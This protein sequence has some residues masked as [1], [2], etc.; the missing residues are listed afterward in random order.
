[1]TLKR[2]YK[3][4]GLLLSPML[5]QAQRATFDSNTP[6]HKTT[7]RRNVGLQA[8]NENPDQWKLIGYMLNTVKQCVIAYFEDRET[9]EPLHIDCPYGASGDL[10][11]FK[12]RHYVYGLWQQA[13]E[14]TK[15]GRV[16]LEFLRLVGEGDQYDVR[17][18]HNLP[19]AYYQRGKHDLNIAHWY[20]RPS[21]Y[22]PKAYAQLWAMQKDPRIERLCDITAMDAVH[23]GVEPVW[24]NVRDRW[25]Y[26]N[27]LDHRP[28]GFAKDSFLSLYSAING[29][30]EKNKNPWV[31]VLDYVPMSHT[32]RPSDELIAKTRRDLHTP[33]A[34]QPEFLGF[35]DNPQDAQ[36]LGKSLIS[37]IQFD[38]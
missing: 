19:A 5:A 24:S 13:D 6:W 9:D 35:T 34:I 15:T 29:V 11:Y 27:Y 4:R 21:L 38:D 8:V 32:G 17:F 16:K 2:K 25:G 33:Y 26:K 10:I 7:T 18:D 14:L 31:W 3:T 36:R 20:E 37:N 28:Y 22:M 23:E 1:M 12:E 30:E